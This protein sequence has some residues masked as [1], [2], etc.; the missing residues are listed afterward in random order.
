MLKIERNRV[1]FRVRG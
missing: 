1:Y